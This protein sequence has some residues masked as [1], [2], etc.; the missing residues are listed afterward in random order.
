MCVYNPGFCEN[1]IICMS[2]CA[3]VYVSKMALIL[4]KSGLPAD[5]QPQMV[6][7]RLTCVNMCE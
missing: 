1:V 6:A 2:K 7:A 4:N 3:F 5:T